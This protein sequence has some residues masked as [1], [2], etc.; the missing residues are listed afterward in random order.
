MLMVSWKVGSNRRAYGPPLM[1]QSVPGVNSPN[2]FQTNT[3][4]L[5]AS[6]AATATATQEPG[7]ASSAILSRN[8]RW[9]TLH[10]VSKRTWIRTGSIGIPSGACKLPS[11]PAVSVGPV[12][13]ARPVRRKYATELPRDLLRGSNRL[14]SAYR[15]G[16]RPCSS[17]SSPAPYAVLVQYDLRLPRS[18][19][20]TK[21]PYVGRHFPLFATRLGASCDWRILLMLNTPCSC[22]VSWSTVLRIA[23]AES[24]NRP[25]R[26]RARCDQPGS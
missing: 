18:P 26:S 6:P 25:S 5:N 17:L 1:C 13:L 2:P 21:R 14:G 20:A 23:A 19:I 12:R 8:G 3:T 10:L 11:R 16:P 24:Y 9:T 4:S 15:I 7:P 22:K